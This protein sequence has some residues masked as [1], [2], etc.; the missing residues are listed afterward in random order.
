VRELALIEAIAAALARRDGARVVRW[1]G[2]DAAVVRGDAF[3]VTS[4][5]VMVDG[6][7]F[8]LGQASPADVGHRA[9]AAALSDLAAMGV[10]PGEAYLGVVLPPALTDAQALALHEGAE[11]LAEATGTTIAGGDIVAGPVLT[12]AVTV[13]GWASADQP[14]VGRSG[15][16]PGDLVGVTGTLGAAAA[17][18]A[19]LEGRVHEDV[20]APGAAGALIERF[21][22]PVPRLTEGCRLAAAGVHAM[23][24][25]SDGLASDAQR[26]AEAGDVRIVLDAAALPLADGV[27]ELA[28]ALSRDPAELAATGGE[29][30]ELLVCVPPERRAAAEA[31]AGITWIGEVAEGAPAVEWRGAPSGAAGWRGFEH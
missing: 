22:R 30:F 21:L 7:H 2:D 25:L 17:G 24:D 13:V 27:A 18:L 16:R 20:G 15:A 19:V 6:T 5:D 8:R 26:L 11:A 4:V 9:L 28:W 14:L 3:A 12:L 31:A 10:A 1:L 23:L 29:D